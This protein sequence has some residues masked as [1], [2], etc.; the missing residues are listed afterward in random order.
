ME[1]AIHDATEIGFIAGLESALKLLKLE[2]EER[3]SGVDY[4]INSL[5]SFITSKKKEVEDVEDT[6][7]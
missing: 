3:D 6:S 5:E 2:R 4:A 1:T 7:S